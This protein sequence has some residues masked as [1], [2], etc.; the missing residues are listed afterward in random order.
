MH[1]APTVNRGLIKPVTLVPFSKN[2]I[3]K[4]TRLASVY[5]LVVSIYIIL[6]GVYVI[7]FY[8]VCTKIKFHSFHRLEN[9][10]FVSSLRPFVNATSEQMSRNR[11]DSE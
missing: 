11:D 8:M 10:D 7:R 5:P 9:N 1:A 6:C 4:L 2:N 3:N